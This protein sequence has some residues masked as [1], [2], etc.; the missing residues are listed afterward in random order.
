MVVMVRSDRM[1]A[2]DDVVVVAAA[3]VAAMPVVMLV[4]FYNGG[5]C[6]CPD[7]TSLSLTTS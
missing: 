2:G 5:G 4:C 1:H 7:R 3:V 6:Y